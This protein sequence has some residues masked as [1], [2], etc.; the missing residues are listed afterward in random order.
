MSLFSVKEEWVSRLECREGACGR[1]GGGKGA[2]CFLR[3]VRG[4]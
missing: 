3:I 1:E 2:Y 4:G